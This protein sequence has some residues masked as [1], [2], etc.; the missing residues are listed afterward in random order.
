MKTSKNTGAFSTTIG[1]RKRVR[2]FRT[3]VVAV[4]ITLSAHSVA[5][6][7]EVGGGTGYSA[8]DMYAWSGTEPDD[9]GNST[10]YFGAQILF[11]L[12]SK[13]SIGG[14]VIHQYLFWYDY[15]YPYGTSYIYIT[16]EVSATRI[17][18]ILRFNFNRN[19]LDL[20][21]GP[22]LF[23]DFVD[24]SIGV[25]FGRDFRLSDKIGLPVKIGTN[26]IADSDAIVVPITIGIGFSYRFK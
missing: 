6:I 7:I 5:Q 23:D 20:S 24:L 1:I 11:P 12:G 17:A 25:Q 22:Y 26:I 14:G 21:V 10:S 4:L 3:F 8:V 16:Q 13:V 18:G 19:F 9:W 2:I 15:R